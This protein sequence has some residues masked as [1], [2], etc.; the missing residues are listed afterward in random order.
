MIEQTHDIVHVLLTVLFWGDGC[1]AFP[2]TTSVMC[3]HTKARRSQTR[4]DRLLPSFL[5]AA[6]A[7]KQ[8]HR[9]A[10]PLINVSDSNAVGVEHSL[11]SRLSTGAD[12]ADECHREYCVANR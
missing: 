12:R 4:N 5:I 10:L 2:M 11:R 7:V 8:E 3:N 1:A 6:E 9:V